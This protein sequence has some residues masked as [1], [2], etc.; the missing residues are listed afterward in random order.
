MVLPFDMPVAKLNAMLGDKGY[1]ADDVRFALLM[2]GILPVIPSK[3][4]RKEPVP[5][6]LG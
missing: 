4:N 3:A 2:R 5:C 6:D 1:D